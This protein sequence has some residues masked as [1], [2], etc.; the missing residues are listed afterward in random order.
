M[1]ARRY[2]PKIPSRV[3]HPKPTRCGLAQDDAPSSSHPLSGRAGRYKITLR[4]LTVKEAE[5]AERVAL[6]TML[7]EQVNGFMFGWVWVL[8]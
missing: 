8:V 2:H 5:F 7:T 6:S 3:P 1:Y 4:R